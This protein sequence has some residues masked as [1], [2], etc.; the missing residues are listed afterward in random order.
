M[1]EMTGSLAGWGCAT[2]GDQALWSGPQV[3]LGTARASSLPLGAGLAQ[4]MPTPGAVWTLLR[5]Q[6]VAAGMEESKAGGPVSAAVLYTPGDSDS[7]F[8]PCFPPVLC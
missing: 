5:P 7:I 1:L 6:R 2:S 8:Y 4:E 3:P